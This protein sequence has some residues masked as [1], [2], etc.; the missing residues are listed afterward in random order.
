M[1]SKQS[2]F[3][4]AS[5]KIKGITTETI[6]K[7]PFILNPGTKYIVK[8]SKRISNVIQKASKKSTI[9]VKEGTKEVSKATK[10]TAK[11]AK[12]L[13]KNC[14]LSAKEKTTNT[15]KKTTE[16]ITISDEIL[17]TKIS[18]KTVVFF[19]L[20]F[21]WIILHAFYSF[22]QYITEISY[23]NIFGLASAIVGSIVML[24][25]GWLVICDI[26]GVVS[27]YKQGDFRR[28]TNRLIKEGRIND[29]KTILLTYPEITKHQIEKLTITWQNKCNV[30][31]ILND[32]TKIVLSDKDEKI[33]KVINQYAV[34]SAA[35]NTVSSKVWLDSVITIYFYFKIVIAI[36]KIYHIKIGIC[37]FIKLITFG[38]IG[39][40]LSSLV[41]KV[42]TD[43]TKTVPL[44]GG[45]AEAFSN[46]TAIRTLGKNIQNSIRPV[47][48]R[49]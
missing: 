26:C 46:G 5:G 32:Y 16:I 23:W 29:L 14:I 6:K 3:D 27:I 33:D 41:Q 34:L 18:N 43:S 24:C 13:V 2:F 49:K 22:T 42:V 7:S 15:Y 12:K 40:G 10:E 1:N 20:I 39:T 48:K 45:V 4:K 36:A 38:F 8:G 30:D 25:L 31:D 19:L 47:R 21:L 35:L 9:G 11:K 37:S 44:A 17:E 28:T